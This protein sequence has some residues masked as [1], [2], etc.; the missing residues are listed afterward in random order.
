M[1]ND[2]KIHF[3]TLL[4]KQ[5]YNNQ[6]LRMYFVKKIQQKILDEQKEYKTL[7]T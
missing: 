2:N 4:K 3:P 6:N 7:K 5:Y 1:K